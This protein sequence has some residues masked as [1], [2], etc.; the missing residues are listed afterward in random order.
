MSKIDLSSFVVTDSFFGAPYIDVD[1]ERDAPVAHRYL[2]GGFEGTDTRFSIWFPPPGQWQGRMY[3]PLEGANAGHE[4]VFAGPLGADIGGLE[5]TLMRLGGYMVESNMGHIGDVMDPRAGTDPTIYGWRA[6]A[7]SARF[8]KFAAEQVLGAQPHHSYVWG[9]S[10]GARRSPLCLAY[11][12]DVWDGALPFMGDALDGEYGDFNR[13]RTFAQ[14]FCSMFNVQRVLGPKVY[15]VIDAALPGGSGD[16]FEGLDTHQREELATLYRLGYPRGDEFMIAQPMG[17]IWLWSSYADRLQR[18]YPDYWEAFW[19]K[20]G[21]VG[22]DQP[23]HVRDDLIDARATVVRGLYARDLIDGAQFQGHEYAQLRGMAALFASMHNMWDI[24]LAVELDHV[25]EGYRLGVGLRL[26]S[27]AATGRQLY[28][29][30]AVGNVFLCDGEGEAS[31]RR[32]SG[33]LPGDE[34]HVDNHAFLAYCYAYR[35]HLTSAEVDYSCL[36]VDDNPI[37]PQYEIP[38]MSPFMGTVHTGRFEGKMMWVHHTHDASLWPSQGIGMKRNVERER[39]TE[40]ARY[41]CLRWTEN[42]EHV[43]PSMAASPPGRKNNTWLISYQPVIEQCLVDL[44]AWVEQGVQ[45]A[46]SDFAYKDGRIIL[47]AAAAERGGIQPVVR[48]GANGS[49]RAEVRV[50]DEVTLNV[51][52]EVPPGQG[53]V[54]SVRWDFD[55]SGTYPFAHELVAA[56][57]GINL[58]TTHSWDRPGTYF[59]TALVESHRDGDVH[60]T[61]RRIPNLAQARVIVT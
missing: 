32:F 56:L 31:N 8:S 34:V 41:F 2:H 15:D 7:E 25:P 43:V 16:P 17:Q 19:T 61:S 23:Q 18:D 51:E 42:A 28:A 30:Q 29:L 45:P 38:E 26:V 14:H 12:P 49:G 35:H 46:G 40:A 60:A 50:G 13:L 11:G 24:P 9:G 59:A 5:M 47:P 53:S 3:Q 37:Y 57:P 21:H 52:A 27:G 10:G 1:E 22:H 20:P 6:A 33:V 54:I 39:G 4:D 55:G 48:V 58:T 44:A 36:R